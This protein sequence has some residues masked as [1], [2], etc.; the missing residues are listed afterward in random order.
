MHG[1]YAGGDLRT[2]F[3]SKSVGNVVEK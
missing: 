1:R 2:E 3:A